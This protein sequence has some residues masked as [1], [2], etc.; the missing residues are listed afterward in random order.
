MLFLKISIFLHMTC[1]NIRN[2]VHVDLFIWDKRC[3]LVAE[4]AVSTRSAGGRGPS[5][6]KAAHAVSASLSVSLPFSLYP[7]LCSKLSSKGLGE[8]TTIQK[9]RRNRIQHTISSKGPRKQTTGGTVRRTARANVT[10][11][12]LHNAYYWAGSTLESRGPRTPLPLAPPL[13]T[14]H[15]ISHRNQFLLAL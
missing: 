12:I 10:F 8:Q 2:H 13:Q 6:W 4:P 14:C 1:N 7:S 11:S 15:F 3:Q 5:A 9:D